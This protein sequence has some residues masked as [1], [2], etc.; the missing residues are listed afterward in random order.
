MALLNFWVK[1]LRFP[2]ETLALTTNIQI[3]HAFPL[4]KCGIVFLIFFLTGGDFYFNSLVQK[5]NDFIVECPYFKKVQGPIII[6]RLPW[7]SPLKPVLFSNT[8]LFSNIL[9]FQG[10]FRFTEKVCRVQSS[11]ISSSPSPSFPYLHLALVWYMCY[12]WWTNHDTL[13][14]AYSLQQGS[15]REKPMGSDKS[16]VSTTVPHIR[17]SLP[18]KCPMLHL[19]IPSPPSPEPLLITFVLLYSFAFSKMSYSWNHT[20]TEPFSD[21]LLSPTKIHLRFFHVFLWLD[22]LFFLSLNYISLSRYISLSIH[23]LKEIGDA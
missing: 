10:I 7:D 11:C 5:N 17:V 6:S 19:F 14:K 23:L 12:K 2:P 18:W 4:A 1:H 21:W 9:L 22:K 16:M 3:T 20:A 8:L 15:L 13:T